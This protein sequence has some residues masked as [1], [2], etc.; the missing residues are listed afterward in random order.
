MAVLSIHTCKLASIKDQPLGAG[1]FAAR[2]FLSITVI[3]IVNDSTNSVLD[4]FHELVVE[5]NGFVQTWR[6]CGIPC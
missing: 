6:D 1:H 3:Y 5:P 4:A 2:N